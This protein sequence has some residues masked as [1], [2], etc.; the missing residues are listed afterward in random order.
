MKQ[1]VRWTEIRIQDT[2]DDSVAAQSGQ[3]L[4]A[5]LSKIMFL[6]KQPSRR[7]KVGRRT[8][9]GSVSLLSDHK[10]RFLTV[11]SDRKIIPTHK[12]T[13]GCQDKFDKNPSPTK[14]GVGDLPTLL[15]D[16]QREAHRSTLFLID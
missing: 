3:L 1:I 15:E 9:N 8:G 5:I 7:R 12:Y 16:C 10:Y 2:T 4:A 14:V 11:C 6:V 13:D